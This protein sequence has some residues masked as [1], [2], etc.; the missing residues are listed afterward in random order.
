MYPSVCVYLSV[1]VWDVLQQ[2][3]CV[4]SAYQSVLL[5]HQSEPLLDESLL[6]ITVAS[7]TTLWK[8]GQF[9]HDLIRETNKSSSFYL[10][11][12][13]ITTAFPQLA[14][15]SVNQTA[16]A[17]LRPPE[18]EKPCRRKKLNTETK[19]LEIQSEQLEDVWGNTTKYSFH[20]TWS[21]KSYK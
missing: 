15:K 16:S 17:V 4:L 19:N 18:G 6:F 1:C 2:L 11:G 9:R 12:A 21:N 7:C 13:K 14:L 3:Q 5:V 8:K 10:F 20:K